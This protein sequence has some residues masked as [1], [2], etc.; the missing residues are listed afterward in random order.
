MT[1]E[2]RVANGTDVFVRRPFNG[3]L[4]SPYELKEDAI[5]T[6]IEADP[7]DRWHIFKHKGWFIKVSVNSVEILKGESS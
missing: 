3:E 6:C 7:G 2:I 4:W 1:M 5:A